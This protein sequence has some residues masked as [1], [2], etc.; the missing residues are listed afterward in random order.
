MEHFDF[1]K[2]GICDAQPEDRIIDFCLLLMAKYESKSFA[3]GTATVLGSGTWNG[4]D[5]PETVVVAAT[6]RHCLTNLFKQ[7]GVAEPRP[8]IPGLGG[9]LKPQIPWL[10]LGGRET[11]D[12]QAL[13]HS[14]WHC[15][16]YDDLALIYL[17]PVN[18][19]AKRTTF[20]QPIISFFS[21][22]IGTELWGFGFAGCNAVNETTHNFE[23]G[24]KL[25]KG[26]II[27]YLDGTRQERLVTD[28]PFIDGMSGGPVFWKSRLV[29]LV[30]SKLEG[31]TNFRSFV[32]RIQMLV[33]FP[34]DNAPMLNGRS[35]ATLQGL[36]EAGIIATLRA[37]PA[38]LLVVLEIAGKGTNY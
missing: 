20:E 35:H 6:A 17:R 7:F 26:Q 34:I 9:P 5:G 29:G 18:E 19:I 4:P 33:H 10:L 23:T 37:A 12:G 15:M 27:Q 31:G 1:G 3:A 38:A 32:M 2:S 13:W 24:A 8:L 22:E 36:A 25:T 11:L 30:S 28:L 14:I 21:P 16:W